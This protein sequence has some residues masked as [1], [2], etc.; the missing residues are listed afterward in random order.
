M[1]QL[2]DY[3]LLKGFA[4]LAKFEIQ[5]SYRLGIDLQLE[6]LNLA[7]GINQLC[8][9]NDWTWLLESINFA[10]GMI[11]LGYWILEVSSNFRRF[12]F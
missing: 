12:F 2:W 4:V 1:Q 5:R 3:F 8:Y 11:E 6:W 10:I 9:W 7:I